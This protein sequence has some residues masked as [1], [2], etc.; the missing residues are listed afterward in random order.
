MKQ[1]VHAG[2]PAARRPAADSSGN[3]LTQSQENADGTPPWLSAQSR[4]G[5]QTC[6]NT[7]QLPRAGWPPHS[8]T[9]ITLQLVTDAASQSAAVLLAGEG[10]LL[11]LAQAG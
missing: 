6:R 5:C 2:R 4:S 7:A 8:Q 9:S 3:K 11:A 1:L 10:N